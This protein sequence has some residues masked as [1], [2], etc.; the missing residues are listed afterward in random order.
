MEDGNTQPVCGREMLLFEMDFLYDSFWPMPYPLAV[1]T[2]V[3]S[4][5]INIIYWNDWISGSLPFGIGTV[6]THSAGGL[7]LRNLH[8]VLGRSLIQHSQMTP[9]A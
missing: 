5:G 2:R 3:N 4:M 9:G 6:I 7:L 8:L 1:F